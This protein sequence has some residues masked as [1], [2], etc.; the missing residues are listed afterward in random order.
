MSTTP[1]AHRS[2]VDD[3]IAS[4]RAS[5]EAEIEVL[6]CLREALQNA[7]EA[8]ELLFELRDT[9]TEG[10]KSDDASA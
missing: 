2:D 1:T 4:I 3:I 6:R 5:H 9:D 10:E 8:L 7:R